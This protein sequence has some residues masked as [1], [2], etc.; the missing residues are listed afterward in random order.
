M[1]TEM[2]SGDFFKAVTGPFGLI[3]D[4]GKFAYKGKQAIDKAKEKREQIAKL[5][6]D[7][8]EMGLDDKDSLRNAMLNNL[9]S[10]NDYKN[11]IAILES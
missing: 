5:K 2:T 11:I 10:Y 8:K 6:A 9:I 3:W 1:S 4:L 7:L